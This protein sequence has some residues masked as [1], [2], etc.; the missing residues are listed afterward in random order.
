MPEPITYRNLSLAIRF[1]TVIFPFDAVRYLELLEENG[2]VLSERIAEIPFGARLEISGFIA[3]KG[4]TSIRL[5]S[6]K[7]VLAVHSPIITDVIEG[8]NFQ[9]TL[10]K[11]EFR[12]ETESLSSFYELTA[13]VYLKS[14]G[15]PLESWRAH[16]A[17]DPLLNQVSNRLKKPVSPYGLRFAS[18]ETPPNHP[19]WF[20]IMFSP[21]V[22]A[23]S[24][25]HEVRIVYRNHQREDVM[26]F[27]QQA[28]SFIYALQAI[29]E[30]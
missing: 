24:E 29:I 5:D 10:L 11:K 9:E 2:F 7:Q 8:L 13:E 17:N 20:E 1:R 15:N 27:A 21:S 12:L 3:R 16:F 23:P 18:K 30:K 28:D 4:K 19:D 6:D 26:K 22:L 14:K 25:M